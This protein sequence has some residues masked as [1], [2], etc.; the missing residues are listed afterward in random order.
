MAML[1]LWGAAGCATTGDL[2]DSETDR[3]VTAEEQQ[4]LDAEYARLAKEKNAILAKGKARQSTAPQ[5]YQKAT[6]LESQRQLASAKSL[7]VVQSGKTLPGK[8]LA[9]GPL[10]LDEKAASFDLQEGAKKE[11]P[12]MTTY[13]INIKARKV[14]P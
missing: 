11:I 13:P 10:K 6:K 3:K 1:L 2:D 14:T 7:A 8:G 9:V 4:R 5:L 12:S